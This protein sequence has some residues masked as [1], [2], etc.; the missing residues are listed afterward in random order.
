VLGVEVDLHEMHTSGLTDAQIAELILAQH[1]GSSTQL[2]RFLELY[3]AALPRH[4]PRRRGSVMPGVRS[5]LEDLARDERVISL[6]L[7]GNIEAGALAKLRHY[8]LDG[9]ITEGAFCRGPGE[10]SE[11]GRVALDAAAHRI[12]APADPEWTFI[13]GDTP[14]DVDCARE[15]GVRSIAVA[16]GE[17][18]TEQLAAAAAWRVLE[19]LPDPANFRALVGLA[20][21]R[22]VPAGR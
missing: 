9:L 1:G 20:P 7:T 11:I 17:Y 6:L 2:E 8:G 5:V 3:G 13:I 12:G 22:A 18:S 16:T 19:R 15:L 10:R 14:R 21:P 4:L